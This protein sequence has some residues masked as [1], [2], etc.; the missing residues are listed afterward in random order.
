MKQGNKRER[1]KITIRK[2]N[3]LVR[4]T[5]LFVRTEHDL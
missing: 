1:K 2:T 5:V 3:K 4:N